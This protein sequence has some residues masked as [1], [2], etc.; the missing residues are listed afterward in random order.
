MMTTRRA[1][2]LWLVFIQTLVVAGS[3]LATPITGDGWNVTDHVV[4]DLGDD[5]EPVLVGSEVDATGFAAELPELG[6]AFGGRALALPNPFPAGGGAP[7]DRWS[8]SPTDAVSARSGKFETERRS[9]PS[10]AM[11]GRERVLPSGDAPGQVLAV[12]AEEPVVQTAR[13]VERWMVE[14]VADALDMR[15][16]ERAGQVSFSLAGIE[17][18]HLTRNDDGVALGHDGNTLLATERSNDLARQR[19]SMAAST[20]SSAS[21]Q[22]SGGIGLIGQLIGMV[23]DAIEY[24]LFWVVFA[25]LL[26]GKIAWLVARRF[27]A[28]ERRQQRRSASSR[29]HERRHTPGRSVRLPAE[30]GRPIAQ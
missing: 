3:P 14:A 12:E 18:L 30:A 4:F 22:A 7:A 19:S 24:P 9:F 27:S 25:L 21:V 29:R 13:E 10:A 2:L 6:L 17:E 20:A 1:R 28:S 5:D 23:R 16:T 11:A 8:G 15:R 26:A